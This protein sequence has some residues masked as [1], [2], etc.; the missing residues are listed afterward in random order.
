MQRRNPGV[1]LVGS[2]IIGDDPQRVLCV[3]VADCVPVLLSSEDGSVVAAIHCG[4]RGVLARV[5]V[6]ALQVLREIAGAKDAGAAS[7][8]GIGYDHFEVG[9]EVLAQFAGAFGGEIPMRRHDDGKGY[10][11]LHSAIRLQLHRAGLDLSRIDSTDRCTFR[12]A[13]EFFSHR[14]DHGITGRMAALIAPRS[15]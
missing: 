2:R 1:L 10:I 6:N 13:D 11:D 4:W 3:R 12:D 8:A 14:R 15:A 7:G 9:A 5:V